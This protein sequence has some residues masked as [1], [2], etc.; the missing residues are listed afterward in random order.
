MIATFAPGLPGTGSQPVHFHTG[1]PTPW[2]EG[3]VIRFQLADGSARF[4][5]L[6]RG[7]GYSTKIVEWL[8]ANALI[9]FVEGAT[10]FVRESSLEEWRFLDTLGIDC[11]V[12]PSGELALVTTCT[13]VVALN[14]D[15]SQR[16]RRELAIGGVIIESIDDG[17]VRGTLCMD[18]P[19]GWF[20]FSL[21]LDSGEDA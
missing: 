19:E 6:Q 4:G 9:I 3:C 18:P 2:R 14:P 15:G 7:H 8:Q 17:V 1:Q 13:D 11:T 10:Y 12:T 21:R 16:W 20:S 5:N